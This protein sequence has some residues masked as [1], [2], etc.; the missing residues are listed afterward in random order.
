MVKMSPHSLESVLPGLATEFDNL[1]NRQSS[2]LGQRFAGATAGWA[3]SAA[4]AASLAS[5]K[6][7]AWR[8]LCQPHVGSVTIP[9]RWDA[10]L[11]GQ[12][13]NTLVHSPEVGGQPAQR[14]LHRL[15]SALTC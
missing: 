9:P 10:Y 8:D 14:G 12:A 2:S 1:R 7:L 4:I 6:S 11:P 5:S 15:Q 13:Q 3:K